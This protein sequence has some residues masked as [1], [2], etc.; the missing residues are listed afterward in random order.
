MEEQD[1]DS[2]SDEEEANN[3]LP[4]YIDPI[5]LDNVE[6]PAISPF[7][8]VMGYATWVRCLNYTEPKERCPFTKKPLRL[9]QIIKLTHDNIDEYRNKIVATTTTS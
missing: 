7:G 3:P 6:K 4:D 8:H 5:T 1:S 2:D 9:R